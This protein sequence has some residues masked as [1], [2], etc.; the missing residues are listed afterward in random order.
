MNHYDL[1]S[2]GDRQTVRDRIEQVLDRIEA[3]PK[4]LKWKMRARIGTPVK[5]YKDV[6]ELVR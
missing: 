3:E 6:G 5:W 1:L 2:E 4:T